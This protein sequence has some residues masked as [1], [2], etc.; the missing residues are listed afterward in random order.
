MS[1]LVGN[2]EDRFS[3]NEAHIIFNGTNL[4]DFRGK[5]WHSYAPVICNHGSPPMGH[6]RAGIVSQQSFVTIARTG[7]SRTSNFSF[8]MPSYNALQSPSPWGGQGIAVEMSTVPAG[9]SEGEIPG[10]CVI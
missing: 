2:P 6:S 3:H 7:H 4:L 9:R 8:L 5:C 1:D 10:I